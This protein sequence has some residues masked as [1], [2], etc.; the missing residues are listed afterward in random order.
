MLLP[1][2]GDNVK[3]Q[4]ITAREIPDSRGNPA[5]HLI[6][7]NHTA[8]LLSKIIRQEISY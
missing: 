8:I 1:K 7:N 2:G 3:A 5:E 4:K 6:G